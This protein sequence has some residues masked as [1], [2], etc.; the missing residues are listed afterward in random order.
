M[1]DTESSSMEVLE[2]DV[3]G[4]VLRS[5]CDGR[6]VVD[7]VSGGQRGV[8]V[9]VSGDAV[10]YNSPPRKLNELMLEHGYSYVDWAMNGVTGDDRV[11]FEYTSA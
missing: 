4:T 6:A 10:E 5:N 3:E 2:F 8:K 7:D 11:I 1:S 9:Y